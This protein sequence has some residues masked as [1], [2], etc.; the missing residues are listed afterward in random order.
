MD[1][2]IV[3]ILTL[4]FAVAGVLGQMK[5][6]KKFAGDEGQQEASDS[7][8]DM[9]KEELGINDETQPQYY[10]DPVEVPVKQEV[11]EKKV[12]KVSSVDYSRYQFR[13][14]NEGTSE[15]SQEAP[16][17]EK[18]EKIS[19]GIRKDFTLRKAVIYSEIL[20]RKYD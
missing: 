1:D 2:L 16:K 6:K 9:F 12:E 19:A 4:V 17:V 10:E 11:K 8:L 15:I 14:E 3:I 20:N 7:I 5:K 13:S 18:R